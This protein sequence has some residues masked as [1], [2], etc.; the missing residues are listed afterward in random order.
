MAAVANAVI[1]TRRITFSLP[2]PLGGGL[3]CTVLVRA[4]PLLTF[5][6]LLCVNDAEAMPE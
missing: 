2:L 5:G 1:N 3:A 6:R 4:L